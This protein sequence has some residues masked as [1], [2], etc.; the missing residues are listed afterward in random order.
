M[1]PSK[2]WGGRFSKPTAREI[3]RFTHSLDIDRQIGREDITGSIA[4][5][6]MLGK[7]RIIPPADAKKLVSSLQKLLKEWDAG[8]IRLDPSAE[9]IHTV[10]QK[11]IER[12]AGKS[13]GRLHTA[14][15]RNDQVVT[16]FKL[17]CNE[18]LTQINSQLKTLQQAILKQAE[19]NQTLL[20]PGYTHWRHS[21]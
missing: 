2:L 5:A 13:A 9:D 1:S 7:Q 6:R 15:S 18:R 12:R 14:R 21:R 20:M 16:A 4:H 3:E 8:K 19:K 11:E 10:I 17:H